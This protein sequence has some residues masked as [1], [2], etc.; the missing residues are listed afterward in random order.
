MKTDKIN[1]LLKNITKEVK[2]VKK[3]YSDQ[4]HCTCTDK[5]DKLNFVASRDEEHYLKLYALCVQ[6]TNIFESV[7]KEQK[8]KIACEL[9]SCINKALKTRYSSFDINHRSMMKLND[10]LITLFFYK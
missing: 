9:T 2:A 6:I 5:V 1:T 4:D 7:D 3:L 8:N 10:S